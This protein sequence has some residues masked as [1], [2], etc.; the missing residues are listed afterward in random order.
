[1]GAG[2]V[3]DVLTQAPAPLPTEGNP[4]TNTATLRWGA[5]ATATSYALTFSDGTTAT[6]GTNSHPM[7]SATVPGSS[8]GYSVR[9]V[10]AA[11]A[12]TVTGPRSPAQRIPA[13][14]AALTDLHYDGSQVDLEWAPVAGI[15][16]SLI[17]I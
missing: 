15:L 9:A 1:M 5:V 11:G 8:L 17:H 7:P 2:V 14:G 16:L 3:V 6:A 12:V 13:T 4:V 10:A